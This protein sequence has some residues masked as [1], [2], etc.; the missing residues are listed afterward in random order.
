[1]PGQNLTRVE[2]QERKALVEVESYDVELDLTTSETTFR[3]T[4]T[5]RFTATP[6]A[7]T[8]ID[9]ITAEVHSV[10]LNGAELGAAVADGSR[11]ALAGLAE[12]NE[13]VVVADFAYTNT[14][15]GLHRFVDP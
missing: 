11:I 1:M 3:S 8:F 5:V 4:T 12:S 14:G 7:S 6:G 9:A 13:L 15:E 2:A 10:V